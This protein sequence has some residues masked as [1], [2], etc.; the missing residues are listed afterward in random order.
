MF[1]STHRLA[2]HDVP[3]YA[4]SLIQALEPRVLFSSLDLSYGAGGL[5]NTHLPIRAAATALQ[6]DGKLLI[7]GFY[8]KDEGVTSEDRAALFRLNAD[9]SLDT[10]F[11]TGGIFS[12][13]TALSFSN[14]AVTTDGKIIVTGAQDSSHALVAR[15]TSSGS[16]DSTFGTNA[17]GYVTSSGTIAHIALTPNALFTVDDAETLKKYSLSSG[18]LDTTFANSGAANITTVLGFTEFHADSLAIRPD[19]RIVLTGR[20]NAP[21]PGDDDYLDTT[22]GEGYPATYFLVSLT[23]A[24]A[25][26]TSFDHDGVRYLYPDGFGL[27]V[28]DG[29]VLPAPDNSLFVSYAAVYKVSGALTI[30]HFAPDGSLLWQKSNFG[31]GLSAPPRSALALVPNTST[32]TVAFGS[33]MTRYDIN[34]TQDV[35]FKV[36]D[37]TRNLVLSDFPVYAFSPQGDIYV[38]DNTEIGN[39]SLSTVVLKLSHNPTPSRN[40]I[41]LSTDGTLTIPATPGYD[42]VAVKRVGDTLRVRVNDLKRSFPALSV[43]KINIS[44]FAG[45]DTFRA[46]RSINIPISIDG[47]DDNDTLITGSANDTLLGGFG[48]DYLDGALGSDDLSGGPGGPNTVSYLGRRTNLRLSPD[49]R[50]NDG[51]PGELDNI[52]DDFTIILSGNGND[53]IYGSP[54]PDFIQGMQGDDTIFGLAGQDTLCGGDQNDSPNSGRDWLYAGKGGAELRGGDD[55]DH[56]FG[57]PS[58]DTFYAGPGADWI[59]ARDNHID[60]IAGYFP[61]F[62]FIER[63]KKDQV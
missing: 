48:W 54:N 28:Y 60:T 33:E 5:A 11:A 58:H 31:I 14:V 18:A 7:A 17:S 43:K 2:K 39:D 4:L 42:I 57:S 30:N 9:G 12:L 13:P 16:L 50:P 23:P 19:G 1:P 34:G 10:S 49:N 26:D 59:Y 20:A 62:D 53:R 41:Q 25:K 40:D 32:L 36:D 37:A 56:L 46:D 15:F 6:Q 3:S 47:G 29:V 35:D 51:A 55:R 27:E 52:H 63:D 61:N 22:G 45:D 8:P 44:L 38:V 21:S 24:G